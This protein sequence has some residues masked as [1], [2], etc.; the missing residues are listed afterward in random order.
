MQG[1]HLKNRCN[2]PY[3]QPKEET[4]QDRLIKCRKVF[5]KIHHPFRMKT[6]SKIGNEGDFLNLIKGTYK[7]HLVDII[8]NGKKHEC[9]PPKTGNKARMSTLSIPIY[10]EGKSQATRQEKK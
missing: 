2:L 3:Q 6:F 10:T 1:K 7:K 4:L 9:F 5:D 8:L